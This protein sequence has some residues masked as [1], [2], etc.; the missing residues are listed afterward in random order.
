MA[1]AP[2]K[3]PLAAAG[4]FRIKDLSKLGTTVNGAP[5]P[6]S[7]EMV[8]GG[9]RDL[10]RWLDLPDKARIGLAGVVYLDFERTPKA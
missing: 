3:R 5:L 1:R 6:H 2:A 7:L 8:E 9:V 10:D 4:S